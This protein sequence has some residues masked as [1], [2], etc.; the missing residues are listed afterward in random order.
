MNRS[1]KTLGIAAVVAA[2]ALSTVGCGKKPAP[3]AP[4]AP[5][6]SV[7]TARPTNDDGAARRA[8]EAA[9]A[10]RREAARRKAVLEEMVFFDYDV[11][12]I[13]ADAKRTLD[14]KVEI[15]RADPAIRLTIDGHAD[16][17]GSTEYNLALGMR[18]ATA[19]RDYLTG[20]GL[21]TGRF[22]VRTYGEER[23]LARGT[24][25]AS[26]SRNR[27]GEF[28]VRSGSVAQER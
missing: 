22:E 26:W 14:A 15:L 9:E 13:R 1:W 24:G 8:A 25:E 17:R 5:P 12:A 10:A 21:A 4:P 7:P 27:R 6:A 3:A 20:F 2:G 23:P 16:D 11:S 19:I 18:R 28:G